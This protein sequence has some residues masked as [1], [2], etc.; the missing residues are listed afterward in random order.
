MNDMPPFFPIDEPEL[1]IIGAM[2]RMAEDISYDCDTCQYDDVCSDVESL[3]AMH[4]AV[5]KRKK[6]IEKGNV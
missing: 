5:Q 3:R 2:H 4:Q 6:S 1:K